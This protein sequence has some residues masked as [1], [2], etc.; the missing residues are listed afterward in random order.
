MN[1]VEPIDAMTD[2]QF[3]LYVLRSLQRELGVYG[4]VRFLRTFR[5]SSG[6]YTRDRHLWLDGVTVEQILAELPPE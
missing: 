3:E 5:T 1:A 4:F 2:E 6:D